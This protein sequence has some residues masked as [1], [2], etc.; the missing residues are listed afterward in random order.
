MVYLL[1]LM[2]QLV[3]G[4]EPEQPTRRCGA[5]GG[6]PPNRNPGLE[7]E[8]LDLDHSCDLSTAT[9]DCRQSY[10]SGSNCGDIPSSRWQGNGDARNK[11]KVDSP[12]EG[13]RMTVC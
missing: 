9:G 12:D 4:V 6:S 10:M 8:F 7:T 1:V 13:I 3:M 5:E 11:H 2:P